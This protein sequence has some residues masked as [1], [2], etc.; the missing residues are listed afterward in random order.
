[1]KF[2][3]P[4]SVTII[5]YYVIGVTNPSIINKNLSNL[6]TK[7]VGYSQIID[8]D[9]LMIDNYEIRL[10]DIDAPEW[11]Q[12]CY[13]KHNIRYSCGAQSIKYLKRLISNNIVTCYV[14]GK[15]YYNRY[16]GICYVNNVNINVRMVQSGWALSFSSKSEFYS[17]MLD[18]KIRKVGLWQGKFITPRQFRKEIKS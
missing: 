18:A 5:L 17:S 11:N 9:S 14:K 1:M 8:G 13:S 6:Y 2:M 7:V 4:I 10:F 16:L 15:D 12:K 3:I